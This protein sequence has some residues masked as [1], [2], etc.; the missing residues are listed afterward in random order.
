MEELEKER[1]ALT[2]ALAPGELPLLV[3]QPQEPQD[4]KELA[5]LQAGVERQKL[6]ETL[7]S[8]LPERAL[9][10]EQL[11]LAPLH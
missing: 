4:L 7:P 5:E 9:E 3:A 8:W 10:A 11:R 6:Q 1:Q 2:T